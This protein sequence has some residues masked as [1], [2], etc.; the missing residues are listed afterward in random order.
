MDELVEALRET[1]ATAF[2]LYLKVHGAH[3]NVEGPD[4]P[5]LH[6]LFERIYEDIH[7]SIDDI[8]EKLRQL[9]QHV[10]ANVEAFSALSRVRPF[11]TQMPAAGLVSS[12]TV[13]QEIML[14]VLG[15]AIDAAKEIAQEGIISFLAERVEAHQK[16]RWFLR[17]TSKGTP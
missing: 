14:G 11:T 3:W 12:L 2:I 13:D 16:W 15:E 8:A 17:A 10:D 5:Q 1:L 6:K 9:D 7:D 4:F